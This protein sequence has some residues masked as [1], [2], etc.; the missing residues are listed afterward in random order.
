[1]SLLKENEYWH[2]EMSYTQNKLDFIVMNGEN[3]NY[4]GTDGLLGDLKIYGITSKV[5]KVALKRRGV[6]DPV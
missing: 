1:M 2:V 6:K 5:S 4:K 3:F